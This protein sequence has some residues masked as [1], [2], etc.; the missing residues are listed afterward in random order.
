MVYWLCVVVQLG[1]VHINGDKLFFC[2]VFLEEGSHVFV[3]LY[4]PS[5]YKPKGPMYFLRA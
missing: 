2:F 1:T 4:N 3:F 5:A